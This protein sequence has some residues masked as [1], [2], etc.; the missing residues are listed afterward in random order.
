MP[1]VDLSFPLTGNTVPLDHGYRLYAAVTTRLPD[2]HGA[3]WLGM[4]PIGGQ[5]IDDQ[6]QL[7]QG[8]DLKMRLPSE[9][10]TAVLALAGSRLSIGQSV[11]TLGAPSIRPLIPAAALDARLVLLKLTQPPV[12]ENDELQRTVLDNDAIADRY[13]AE[14]TRQLHAM[15]VTADV[16]LCGRRAIT[17][18]GKRLLGYSVRLTG[19]D[20]DASLRVQE[21]GLGG[22][23]ALGCGLFRP[24][25]WTR[26]PMRSRDAMQP[27]PDKGTRS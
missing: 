19:L 16:E 26:R 27:M 2:L 3:R 10:I 8:S 24:T 17:I 23:R 22:R 25:R 5:I 1:T 14:L 11:I 4:H 6:I 13:R 7:V 18:K 15:E 9:E 20:A 12:R 21:R